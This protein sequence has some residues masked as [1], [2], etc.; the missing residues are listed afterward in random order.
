MRVVSADEGMGHATSGRGRRCG[1][2]R[3]M[4]SFFKNNTLPR[5]CLE[6]HVP[7][8]LILI[9]ERLSEGPLTGTRGPSVSAFR[10]GPMEWATNRD[11][12]GSFVLVPLVATGIGQSPALRP[13]LL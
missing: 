9:C 3:N 5:Q 7:D 12:D 13:N 6:H 11:K 1:L 2:S 10:R 4:N 8:V